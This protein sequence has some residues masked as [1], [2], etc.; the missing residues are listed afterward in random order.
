MN[1]NSIENLELRLA[2]TKIE[3]IEKLDQI[4]TEYNE[5]YQDF[6]WTL[7]KNDNLSLKRYISVNFQLE[8]LDKP[9]LSNEEI[10]KKSLINAIEILPLSKEK[11][12][13]FLE[14]ILNLD[15]KNIDFKELYINN[16]DLHKDDNFPII[17]SLFDNSILN[18]NDLVSISLKYK[19][20]KNFLE[21][22]SWLQDNKKEIVKSNFFELNNTKT[23]DRISLFKSDFSSE[24]KLSTN[25]SIYPKALSFIWKNYFKLKLKNKVESKKD[26]LRRTFK[27][28]FL[29][30]YRLKYSWI[31]INSIINKIDTLDDL[32]SMIN[33]LLKY[34]DILKQNP[35]LQKD[36]IVS[37]EIDIIW[38]LN[39]EAEDN[40]EKMLFWEEK[41]IKVNNLLEKWEK[42]LLWDHLEELLWDN[43]DLVWWNLIKRDNILNIWILAE[44]IDKED[45]NEEDDDIKNWNIN[46]EDF[47]EELKIE[48]DELEKKKNKI[49]LSWGFDLLDEVNNELTEIMLKLDKVSKLLWIED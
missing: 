34:F 10:L 11:K 19:E 5:K 26:L 28:A 1:N 8:K 20:T 13:S 47:Y 23:N 15:K 42:F 30:L 4:E 49:F 33:L 12:D 29:K 18:K 24:I 38:E 7:I 31:D 17:E 22:I 36:Y 46:L 43:I 3:N 32:D 6:F 45:E 27:I 25:I 9:N 21:S 44:N 48:F 14:N 35:T 16:T 41:T 2:Q 40:K 39:N 37:D